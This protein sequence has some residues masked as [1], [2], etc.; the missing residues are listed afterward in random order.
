MTI[1]PQKHINK[2]IILAFAI[3]AM[4]SFY[5]FI[6]YLINNTKKKALLLEQNFSLAEK[7]K[8]TIASEQNIIKETEKQRK[9]LDSYFINQTNVVLFIEK[10]E[11]LGAISGSK[12]AINSV[13]IDKS[14]KNILKTSLS[15][16]GK[17]D[18]LFHFL[19]LLEALSLEIN[20]NRVSLSGSALVL[21]LTQNKS[22]W[23]MEINI[24]L[25]NF[26]SDKQ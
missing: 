23:N 16:S 9:E 6:F 18:E 5:V 8:E 24:E 12:V 2:I 20:V 3:L 15:V 13:D 22:E 25:V 7:K 11:S 26:I 17:F 19:S 10:I 21:P 4:G 1:Q 14:R